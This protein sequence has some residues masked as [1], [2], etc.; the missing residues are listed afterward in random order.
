[1]Y[2][3][4]II[5]AG[6][7]GLVTA[8]YLAGAGLRV[9][10]LES[11]EL[12]GGAC[13][14]EQI[15]PGYRVSTAAYLCSLLQSRVVD[16]LELTRFGYYVEPKDPAFFSPFPDGR[17]LFMWQDR[18]KT[19]EEIAKFSRA[20]AERY[21]AYEEHLEH[22]AQFVEPLL[23]LPPPN[24]PPRSAGDLAEYLRMAGRLRKL[25][26]RDIAALVKIESLKSFDTVTVADRRLAI[27]PPKLPTPMCSRA[28]EPKTKT[29][30]KKFSEAL[31]KITDEDVLVVARRDARTH[32]TVVSGMSQLH[33]Q[34]VWARLKSR[35]N[36]EVVTK[37]P[38]TPYL[39]TITQKGDDHYRHKKQ[40]GGAGEFAE[41]WMRVE[42]LERGKGYEFENEVFGG[43]IAASYVA[44]A[45]KGVKSVMEKGVIAGYPVVDLKVAVYDG[46]EHPVDSK[47]VAFQKAG[48]EA[49][50]LAVKQARPVLLEPIVNLEVTFPGH[51][52]GDITGDLNRRRARVVG[53]DSIGTFQT[54]KAQVPLAEIADYASALGSMSA[55]QGT[56]SI[57]PSHYEVV[58]SSIQQRIV[59]AAKA[60]MEKETD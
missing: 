25:T 3:A 46:K 26:R 58:P 59:E 28:V 49:F 4:I 51:V 9:L 21:P 52:M 36:V 42:P 8:G 44:S 53:M 24:V 29:D 15:W 56:Y 55:G 2:D 39:E 10:V 23:L 14:T 30:E 48:R 60:E 6:H 37:E 35:F 12:V 32:E 16:D 1:M 41:V 27:A 40:T 33:L 5:G 11:R 22:L 50:K 34:V 54:I 18:R 57:E 47:D 13:V 38:K 45:E 7:N 20:D 17:Y 43:A 31:A 19:L